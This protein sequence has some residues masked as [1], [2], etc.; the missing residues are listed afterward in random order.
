MTG[1]GQG[2]FI[3]LDFDGV[4]ADQARHHAAWVAAFARSLAEWLGEPAH[5]LA[6]PVCA[7]IDWLVADYVG[8]F[9]GR[10]GSGYDSWLQVALPS[11]IARTCEWAGVAL[12][13]AEECAAAYRHAR[14]ESL[15]QVTLPVT[16]A[17]EAVRDLVKSGWRIA[18][19]S[20]HESGYLLAAVAG[21]GLG[22]CI[23]TC[24]GPD[25]ID[26]AKSGPEFYRR[27]FAAAGAVGV[28][29]DDTPACLA[30]A[31]EAGAAGLIQSRLSHDSPPLLP[32]AIEMREL[33]QL[34]GLARALR[35]A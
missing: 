32:G 5:R 11:V 14:A 16:G 8:R 18:M 27:V 7:A 34:P 20:G 35:S 24:F 29:V 3:Y 28:V 17:A 19:A 30:W 10:D 4:I 6:G 13:D 21:A 31:R 1:S 2:Q 9:E 12:P 26:S 23:E 15:S 25:L 33:R 22:G